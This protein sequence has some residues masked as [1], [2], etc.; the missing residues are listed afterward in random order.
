MVLCSGRSWFLREKEKDKMQ[1]SNPKAGQ[2]ASYILVWNIF[3][4][5]SSLL[6][7]DK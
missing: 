3:K 1:E 5:L 4:T 2:E 6:E 7:T